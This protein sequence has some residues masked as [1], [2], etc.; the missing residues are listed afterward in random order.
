VSWAYRLYV[1]KDEN[2]RWIEKRSG[3]FGTRRDAERALTEVLASV[4]TGTF[5][6]P[7]DITVDGYLTEEWLPATAPPHVR[8][9]TW[10]DRK[11]NLEQHVI[12]RIGAVPLQELTPAHVNRVYA[13]LLAEGRLDGEGG[14]SPTS[15]RRVH[16]MFRKALNDAVRWGLIERNVVSLADPPPARLAHA[17]RRRSMRTWNWRELRQFLDSVSGHPLERLFA[18]GAFTGMRR[19]E[20]IGLRWTDTD[21]GGGFLAVRS[22]VV[23]GADDYELR[24]DQ[25]SRDSGRTIHLDDFTTDLIR[26]QRGSVNHDRE[27]AG[28]AWEEHGLVF[29]RPDG[30][31]WNPP[32]VSLSFR[33]AVQTSGAPKIRFQ[34]LRHTHA[35]LL[36]RAGVNPK[37]V[38]ERLGHSSVAFTLDT[39]AHVMPGMQPEAAEIFRRNVFEDAGDGGPG[40]DGSVSR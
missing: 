21:L 6:R 25:K 40:P 5:V 16:A 19:S 36:L 28:E 22:I 14:L 1:G 34:D 9:E 23:P 11:R 3:G 29:P 13:E 32:A 7:H 27:A 24:E 18:L 30:R 20:L 31:W 33:R 17:A 8:H 37:V 10:R 2:G 4:E 38:S 12:P 35:T 39:Y 15:V 26:A